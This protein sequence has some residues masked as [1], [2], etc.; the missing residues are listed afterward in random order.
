MLLKRN[1][2][3]TKSEKLW[4]W[5]IKDESELNNGLLVQE[6]IQYLIRWDVS[7]IMKII[8]KPEQIEKD[9]WIVGHIK[10]SIIELN[11]L[12]TEM[13]GVCR[14]EKMQVT[15]EVQ[16]LCA[17]HRQPRE[18]G[19]CKKCSARDYMVHSLEHAT[20]LIQNV[21]LDHL[22]NPDL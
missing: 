15:D 6:Y 7:D 4:D 17:S 12:V 2:P 19:L 14:C 18:V 16:Y 9:L 20:T 13:D 8:S 5:R 10:Q 21:R 11:E 22:H 1:L 3:G